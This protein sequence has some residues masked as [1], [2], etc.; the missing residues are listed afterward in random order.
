MWYTLSEVHPWSLLEAMA[1]ELP[2]IA[3]GVNGI[4]ETIP[5]KKYLVNPE[6]TDDIIDK[7]I[8]FIHLNRSEREELGRNNRSLIVKSF[9]LEAHISK[10]IKIYEKAL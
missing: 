2:V 9:T 7:L 4:A 8:N 1:S 6:N 5:E 3:S 10:L